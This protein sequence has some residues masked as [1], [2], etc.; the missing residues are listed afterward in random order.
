MK[1]PVLGAVHTTKRRSPAPR[2]PGWPGN[3]NQTTRVPS[4]YYFFSFT[5]R[6]THTMPALMTWIP[7][8]CHVRAIRRTQMVMTSGTLRHTQM[9]ADAPGASKDFKKHVV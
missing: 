5:C 1:S 8:W 7:C 6:A 2:E 4:S 3:A 9:V